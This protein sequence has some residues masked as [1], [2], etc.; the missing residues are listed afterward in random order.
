MPFM[1]VLSQVGQ[2]LCAA[3]HA[4]L[5]DY[6]RLIAVLESQ[7][8]NPLEDASS[9]SMTMRRL[10]VWVQE[11]LDRMKLMA[12]IVDTCKGMKGGSLASKIHSFL[13]HGDPAYRCLLYTSPSPRDS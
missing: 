11:P 1:K 9:D 8:A 7:L 4:E 10:F 12:I 2:S 13:Q 5:S 6:Y 3:L